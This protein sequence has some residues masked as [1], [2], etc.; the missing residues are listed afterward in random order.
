[1]GIGCKW[2]GEDSANGGCSSVILPDKVSLSV[3]DSDGGWNSV[4]AEMIPSDKVSFWILDAKRGCINSAA[5]EVILAEEVSLS[6]IDS[7]DGW[8]S[9]AWMILLDKISL[10]LQLVEFH[11]DV[12]VAVV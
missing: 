1:M 10:S 9:V 3:L 6:I 8:N 11:S 12:T 7:D 5:A 4:A 2:C